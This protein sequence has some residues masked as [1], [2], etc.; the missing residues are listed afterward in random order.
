V[1][2][3]RPCLRDS[4]SLATSLSPGPLEGKAEAEA[5]GGL[6]NPRLPPS[7]AEVRSSSGDG[8][9]TSSR[10]L[11]SSGHGDLF[12]I[13]T[14]GVAITCAVGFMCWPAE[15]AQCQQCA[16]LALNEGVIGHKSSLTSLH[17]DQACR[18][19]PVATNLPAAGATSFAG[20]ASLH[21]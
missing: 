2:H 5:T 10:L 20:R 9:A 15:S 12:F 14:A 4:A 16:V 8:S 13:H 6:L 1:P 3:A 7:V 11:A 17:C 18:L 19:G 21:P